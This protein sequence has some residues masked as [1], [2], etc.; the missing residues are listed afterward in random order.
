MAHNGRMA[1]IE[2][3]N[4]MAPDTYQAMSMARRWR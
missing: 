1:L 3:P 2:P 4:A